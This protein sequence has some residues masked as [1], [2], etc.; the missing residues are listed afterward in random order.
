[1][2]PLRMTRTV[3]AALCVLATSSALAAGASAPPSLSRL[4]VGRNDVSGF[5]RGVLRIKS[6]TSASRFAAL[7]DL[8]SSVMAKKAARLEREGFLEGV[9]DTLR[10][11]TGEIFSTAMVFRSDG[12]ANR[13][14][15]GW[16][17]EYRRLFEGTWV[18][19]PP[20]PTIPG[21][22]TLT[23]R[24]RAPRQA[25]A[26]ALVL[27]SSGKCAL[28]TS[29]IYTG[30]GASKNAPDAVSSSASALYGRAKPVCS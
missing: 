4:T 12:A 20:V 5:D 13:Q 14:V 17:A 30:R 25:S 29:V 21:S 7:F 19:G 10:T 8:S 15:A 22:Q 3:L 2:R 24:S 27:F 16:V 6:A 11:S 1:M 26:Y 9:R 18:N 28:L 23:V